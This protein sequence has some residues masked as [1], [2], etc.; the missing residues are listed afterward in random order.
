MLGC[1]LF[2]LEHARHH[3]PCCCHCVCSVAAVGLAV[4]VILFYSRFGS[5]HFHRL[6]ANLVIVSSVSNVHCL[7]G[8]NNHSNHNNR[9]GL[10]HWLECFLRILWLNHVYI[11][12]YDCIWFQGFTTCYTQTEVVVKW[13][14][15]G[16][17]FVRYWYIP[18]SPIVH[19]FSAG[20]ME[21]YG[22]VWK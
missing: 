21:Y 20:F 3:I 17:G 16:I 1:K 19:H 22:F 18:E 10:C 7:K 2:S 15:I 13:R 9:I 5:H 4:G 11:Y 6:R 14:E 12:V 8:A